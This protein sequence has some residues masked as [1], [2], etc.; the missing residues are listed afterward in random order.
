MELEEWREECEVLEFIHLLENYP[1]AHTRERRDREW[2]R[3]C[4]E[5]DAFENLHEWKSSS[6]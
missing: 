5:L 1:E 3:W 4:E 2:E 6:T